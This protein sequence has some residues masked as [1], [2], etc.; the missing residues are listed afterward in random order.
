MF[1]L[2]RRA[3]GDESLPISHSCF[4][5]VELP[6]YSCEEVMRKRLLATVYYGLDAYLMV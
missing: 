3:A 6:P 2:T 1:R 4:F 5:D